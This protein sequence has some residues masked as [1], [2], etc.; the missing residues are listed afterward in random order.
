MHS[1]FTSQA[2]SVATRPV[3]T[4]EM[5]LRR[6]DGATHRVKGDTPPLEGWRGEFLRIPDGKHCRNNDLKGS[7]D[8]CEF[9]GIPERNG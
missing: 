3:V 2:I 9:L 8:S 7:K 6:G 1:F 4:H 5:L